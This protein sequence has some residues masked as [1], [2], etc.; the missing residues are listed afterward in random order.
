MLDTLPTRP[1]EAL[2]DVLVPVATVAPALYYSLLPFYL[3]ISAVKMLCLYYCSFLKKIN[4]EIYIFFYNQDGIYQII[5][6]LNHCIELE[7][8]I[9]TNKKINCLN[10]ENRLFSSQE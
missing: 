10:N 4:F 8:T 2:T 3:C 9:E 5:N 7:F 1:T 6:I